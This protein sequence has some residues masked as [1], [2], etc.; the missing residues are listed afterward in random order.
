[1]R[2]ILLL[3]L[4]L[5]WIP[6]TA[7]AVAL[8]L[9]ELQS[10]LNQRLDA[11]IPLH[12]VS[13]EELDDIQVALGDKAAFAR[14]GLER[15]FVL[16]SLQFKVVQSTSGEAYIDVSSKDP[17]REPYLNFIVDVSSPSGRVMREYSL[18]LNAAEN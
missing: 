9:V 14:A 10:A 12:R 6:G 11:R 13:S 16:T 15:P 5:A 7:S 1:M 4:A 8:G 3:S 17:I 18:L 2:K